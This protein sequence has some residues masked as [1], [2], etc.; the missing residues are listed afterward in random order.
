M[1]LDFEAWKENMAEQQ[2]QFWTDLRALEA[3][4][5]ETARLTEE[6]R[7]DLARSSE[8][9]RANI[10]QLVDVC[11]SLANHGQETDRRIR[12]LRD[13]QAETAERLNVLVQVIDSLVKRNGKQ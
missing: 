6:N 4:Q 3:R 12:E 7:R 8:E 1:P 2:A 5:A 11:M 10:A 13:A 9:T